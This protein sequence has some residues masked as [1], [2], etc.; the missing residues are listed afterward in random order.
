LPDA[1]LDCIHD[2]ALY[3]PLPVKTPVPA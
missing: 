3:R 2:R 1:V